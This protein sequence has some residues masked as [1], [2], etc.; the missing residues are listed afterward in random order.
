[1]PHIKEHPQNQE[2]ETISN[3]ID[4]NPIISSHILQDLNAAQNPRLIF[5]RAVWRAASD[6]KCG[7]DDRESVQFGLA[8][9]SGRAIYR[10]TGADLDRRHSSAVESFTRRSYYYYFVSIQK[11]A[12]SRR[13]MG[14][15]L[16]SQLFFVLTP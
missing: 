10:K 16:P 11:S 12:K 13:A 4:S 6:K 5:G 2:L 1:M 15:I 7:P 14:S 8:P 9:T 3:I